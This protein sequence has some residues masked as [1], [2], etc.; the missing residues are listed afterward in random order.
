M[1]FSFVKKILGVRSSVK[2]PYYYV[3]PCPVCGSRQTGHFILQHRETE[4]DWAIMDALRAGEL[5]VP[6]EE[7]VLETAVCFRCQHVWV[8]DN[9]W[10]MLTLSEIE[11]EKRERGTKELLE[12][13]RSEIKNNEAAKK[14]PKL[15][16]PFAKYIGKI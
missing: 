4:Q 15:I 2:K 7:S 11:N 16:K 1:K 5:V 14:Q 8:A 9:R 3:P 6:V 13:Y 12:E 10:L